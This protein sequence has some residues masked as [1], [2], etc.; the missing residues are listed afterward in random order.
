M[1]N[2][3]AVSNTIA[4][5]QKKAEQAQAAG[6]TFKLSKV[7]TVRILPPEYVAQRDDGTD[8]KTGI[9]CAGVHCS[10]GDLIEMTEFE[11]ADL[12][13]RGVAELVTD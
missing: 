7:V 8:I 9:L 13:S 10:T 3:K 2:L 1:S 5:E 4:A 6:N 11:A 12:I